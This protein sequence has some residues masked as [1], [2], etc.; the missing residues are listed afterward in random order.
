MR[1][2]LPTRKFSTLNKE[3]IYQTFDEYSN[4]D[5]VKI[6]AMLKL[7]EKEGQNS[8]FALYQDI[9]KLKDSYDADLQKI[10]FFNMKE[11]LIS[12]MYFDDLFLIMLQKIGCKIV[13][14]G[15]IEISTSKKEKDDIDLI[16]QYN[17]IQSICDSEFEALKEDIKY[18]RSKEKQLILD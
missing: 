13:S 12:Q 5:N 17:S 4:I 7:L 2:C 6:K 11:T 16:E 15:D 9:E 1:F 8:S 10:L 18:D 14:N 3:T